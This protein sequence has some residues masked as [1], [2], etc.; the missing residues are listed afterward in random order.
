M[1][2]SISN[3]VRRT[4]NISLYSVRCMSFGYDAWVS[5]EEHD[6]TSYESSV[7]EIF[8]LLLLFSLSFFMLRV[9]LQTNSLV[10]LEI[11]YSALILYVHYIKIDLIGLFCGQL[12]T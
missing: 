4:L 12:Y 7:N 2:K 1:Y 9:H 5:D 6:L 8:H 3:I 10:W 11:F